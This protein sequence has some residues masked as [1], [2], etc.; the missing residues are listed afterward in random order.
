MSSGIFSVAITGMSAAQMGLLTTEHNITNANTPGYNRQR[1]IQTTNIGLATGSGFIG[2]GTNVQTVARIYNNFLQTQINSAQ[3]KT[4]ELNTYATQ[5]KQIDNILADVS[6]GVSP[7]LQNFFAGLQAMTSSPSSIAARESF[8]SSAQAL[9][10]RFQTLESRLS[11]MY[12]GVNEQ[13]KNS[14]SLINSY[15]E[16]VA[17]LNAQIVIAQAGAGQPANDLL[18]ARDQLIAELNKEVQVRVSEESDGSLSLFI[19]SGQPLVVG[20]SASRFDVR[21]SASDPER[22]VIGRV[23]GPSAYQELPDNVFSGGNLTGYL[24][25]RSETLDKAADS[26]GQIAA[27]IASVFNAQQGLGQDLLGQVTG[28]AGFAEKLFFFDATNVPKIFSNSRN[29]G[30]GAVVATPATDPGQTDGFLSPTLLNGNFATELRASDYELSFGAGGTWTVKRLTDGV[31][32]AN[33]TGVATATFDGVSIDITAVGD[34]GDKFTIQPVRELASSLRVN[35]LVASDPRLVAAAAPVR[36][37]IGLNAVTGLPNSGNGAVTSI[38]VAPGYV[39][40]TTGAPITLTYNAATQEFSGFPSGPD[41]R[42]Y[43]P[44]GT[45]FTFDGITIRL[46][47]IPADGDTFTVSNNEG[48]VSDSSNAVLMGKLQTQNTMLGDATGGKASFQ[49]VYAQLVS[50]VGNKARELLVTADAQEAL[51]QQAQAARESVS[52]VNTDEEAAN[53]L[54]YQYAYQAAARMLQVGTVLFDTVLSIGR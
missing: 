15:A 39:Q 9:V 16:Q 18:D 4:S 11:E 2:Q 20:Q 46:A 49:G 41:P 40:P 13:L 10:T 14:V 32:V 28:E 50:S 3:T 37:D 25:F 17:T 30:A 48:G 43:D 53:L 1:I 7:A 27:S 33:G 44:S 54:R 35:P 47:G 42:A 21:P 8:V 51:L 6:A 38:S 36:A 5:I 52:G 29:T 24:R 45:E 22:M 34:L 26:L 31:E 12:E 23:I 19:G